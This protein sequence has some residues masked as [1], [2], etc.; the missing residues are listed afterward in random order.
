[1]VTRQPFVFVIAGPNGAGKSTVVT[2]YLPRLGNPP[3]LNADVV[4]AEL[5]PGN[6]DAVLMEA[7]RRVLQAIDDCL[8]A[9]QSFALETTLSGKTYHRMLR[10][11]RRLG[12]EVIMRFVWVRDA[13]Q[14]VRRV[15]ERVRSGGHNVPEDAIRRR[16]AAAL[17][18]FWK[19]YLPLVHDWVFFDNSEGNYVV[20]AEG[21]SDATSE[22]QFQSFL[23]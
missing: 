11:A 14:S 13:D 19:L 15:A 6:P 21:I 16:H 18:N 17:E 12:Y 20:V 5:S 4:A 23:A 3:F 8:N 22:E 1:M 9:R 10:R 2:R 7:G